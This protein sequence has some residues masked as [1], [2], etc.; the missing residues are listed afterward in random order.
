MYIIVRQ[1]LLP[2]LIGYVGE[3]LLRCY[4]QFDVKQEQE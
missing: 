4:L 1:I 3:K 2:K